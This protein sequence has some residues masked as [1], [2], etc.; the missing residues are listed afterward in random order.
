[1]AIIEHAQATGADVVLATDPDCD[2]LGIAA[3]LTTAADSAWATITGNQIGALLTDFACAR[4]KQL[5]LLTD[6][7]YVIKTLVTSDLIRRVSESYNVRCEGNLHVG[8]KWI[9]S[10]MDA[11]GPD[12][13]VLGTE[14]SHGYLIGQYARDKDAAV[15]CLLAAMFVAQLK[16]EGKTLHQRLAEL[17]QQHGCH[18][19]T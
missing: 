17:Q 7:S 2:R 1:D 3:P 15:A 8:F 10:V 9:A 11:V 19:E 12:E 16:A 13:F 18:M 6:K 14:E 5:G 4:M